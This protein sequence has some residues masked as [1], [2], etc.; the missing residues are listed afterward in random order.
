MDTLRRQGFPLRLLP[1]LAEIG[2]SAGT[3]AQELHGVKRGTPVAV[4]MGDMQCAIRAT[5]PST[6][7]SSSSSSIAVL[8][9]NTSAQLAFLRPHGFNLSSSSS[10]F[11]SAVEDVPFG[12]NSFVAVAAAL[13][14]GNSLAKFVE[15]LQ[16]WMA[17][18]GRELPKSDIWKKIGMLKN[19]D[20]YE[21]F[22]KSFVMTFFSV[23]LEKKGSSPV[24]G[25]DLMRIRPLLYSER[26]TPAARA[27]ATD[28][29]IGNLSLPSVVRSICT[30]IVENMSEMAPP[31][32]LDAAGVEKVVATGACVEKHPM[33]QEAVFKIFGGRSPEIVQEG[34]SCVGAAIFVMD[35]E[36]FARLGE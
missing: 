2:E 6:P 7:S 20:E 28:I 9:I 36:H 27:S 33:L 12:Q 4:A 18:L 23:E 19:R 29:T 30:G 1:S 26:H 13:N 31:E 34:N 11:P 35:S 16:L 22:L 8:N 32:L 24:A 15:T 17:E 3:L 5:L 21:V 10:S 25:E 14:G